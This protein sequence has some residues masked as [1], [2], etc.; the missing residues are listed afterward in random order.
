MLICHSCSSPVIIIIH[1]ARPVKFC[2]VRALRQRNI[3][4][5]YNGEDVTRSVQQNARH[6]SF[7]QSVSLDGHSES[8]CYFALPLITPKEIFLGI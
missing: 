2:G 1:H 3:S 7:A 6:N 4:C 5:A 8:H